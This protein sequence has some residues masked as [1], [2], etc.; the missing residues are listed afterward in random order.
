MMRRSALAAVIGVVALLVTSAQMAALEPCET[1]C[2]QVTVGDGKG[3]KGKTVGIP[4]SFT[5]GPDDGM[6]GQGNDEVAAVAF[7]LGIPGIEGA[8]TP[9]LLEC[10]GGK[11]AAGAVQA[12]AAIADHFTVVV[13]NAECT[14]RD[15]C[16]CPVDDQKRDNFVNIV[17]YGPKDL[18][19]SGPVEIPVLPEDGELMTVN[20][21]VGAEAVPEQEITLHAF[22]EVTD[23]ASKP[24]FAA[25]LSLGDK[26]AVD[27][28]ADREVG[29]SKVKFQ[30][31]TFTVERS[32]QA[33][34]G[35][36]NRD[37]EVAINELITGVNIALGNNDVSSCPEFDANSDGEVTINEL[38]SGVN[39]A[40]NGCQA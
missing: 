22:D 11:L 33:C 7:T 9:L 3:E 32:T 17:V 14:N 35:D 19:E 21:I 30:N 36:C 15:S 38:I 26:A 6:A 31:G 27:Q 10:E 29:V 4:I 1:D 39:N 28:T 12:S 8:G 5:Q 13:E 20:L 16:L 24:Q 25:F 18:P 40:L 34:V 2:A 37:G 23:Q